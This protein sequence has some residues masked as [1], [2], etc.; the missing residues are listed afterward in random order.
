MTEIPVE[1]PQTGQPAYPQPEGVGTPLRDGDIVVSSVPEQ[2]HGITETERISTEGPVPEDPGEAP[3][4]E[5]GMEPIERT[6]EES[7]FGRS[8]GQIQAGY[9]LNNWMSRIDDNTNL[10]DISIPGTHETCAQQDDTA[11]GHARCQGKNLEWQLNNGVRFIDIR[12]YLR[13]PNS[14]AFEIFHGN[15][16]QGL[17]FGGGVLSVCRDFLNRNPSETILMRISETKSNTP[18]DFR[19]VF[20]DVYLK[21]DDWEPWFYN[22]NNT[23]AF[24][25]LKDV[26]KKIVLM[27]RDPYLNKG[28]NLDSSLFDTQDNWNG[29]SV[30]DKKNAVQQHLYKAIGASAPK[31]K[32]FLNYTS[33][34]KV[35]IPCVSGI[36]PW[37]YA[38]ELNPWILAKINES[39]NVPGYGVIIMDWV[40]RHNGSTSGGY[41]N[42]MDTVVRR[43]QLRI[44]LALRISANQGDAVYSGPYGGVQSE[45]FLFDD[46]GNGRYVIKRKYSPQLVLTM[47]NSGAVTGESWKS[48]SEQFFILV[49]Q[50]DGSYGIR[51]ADRNEGLVLDLTASGSVTGRPYVGSANQSFYITDQGDSSKGIRSPYY[52]A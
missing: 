36:T 25:A 44:D 11:C 17:Y 1:Y 52:S 45:S 49:N 14:R 26:R 50:A 51:R 24:P 43:N 2:G 10:K 38:K 22:L 39:G 48:S 34:N 21:E 47:N 16:D 46:Y 12:C 6:G 40:D 19:R 42:M 8:S 37:G 9:R 28:F 27:S 4:T 7:L 33:A 15:I 23:S 32:M 30:V 3:G 35:Q 18:N 13:S 29:P 20:N 31:Q 41:T 5:P